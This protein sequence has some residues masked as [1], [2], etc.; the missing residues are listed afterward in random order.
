MAQGAANPYQ[1]SV[2]PVSGSSQTRN[3]FGRSLI[4]L[5]LVNLKIGS[6][7]RIP[8]IFVSIISS[9]LYEFS[10]LPCLRR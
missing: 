4:L 2:S 7:L 10:R 5:L 8:H 1:A 9:R 3:F 6:V